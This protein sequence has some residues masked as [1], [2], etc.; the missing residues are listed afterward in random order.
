MTLKNMV[1]LHKRWNDSCYV[2]QCYLIVNITS[3]CFSVFLERWYNV[4]MFF[5]VL[6]T[7]IQRRYVFQCYFNVDTTSWCCSVFFES[8][9]NVAVFFS[10]IWTLIQHRYVFQCHFN[11]YATSLC[12]SVLIERWYNVAMFFKRTLKN[13]ATLY[14]RS[15][16]TE[17][18]SDVILT[19]K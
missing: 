3:L 2:F 15:R 11:V 17:K 6:W 19:F 10:A 14:Q 12:F 18:H 16:N 1:T 13:I 7:L 9:C 8:W 4:A 5:S